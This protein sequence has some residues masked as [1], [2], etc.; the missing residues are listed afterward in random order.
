[1]EKRNLSIDYALFYLA[2]TLN[3]FF[4]KARCEIE[5]LKDDNTFSNRICCSE[6]C[7]YTKSCKAFSYKT[8]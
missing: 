8:Q 4:L 3:V 1:M 6:N 5:V 7:E 2:R